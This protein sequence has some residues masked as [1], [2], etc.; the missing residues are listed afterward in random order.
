MALSTY[1]DLH[2]AVANWSHRSDLTS[3]LPD[4]ILVAENRI[5][6]DVRCREMETALS[7]TIASG[8]I[9]LPTGYLDLKFAYVDGSPTQS[10][11]RSSASQVYQSYPNRVSDGKPKMIAR[12][13]TNLI[14]G[15]YPDST[16]TI[17]G[18][19]Y[20]Q[21]TS[22][23]TSANALFVKYPDLYLFATLAE[24]ATY[25][26]DQNAVS[27]WNQKFQLIND[28]INAYE[29]KEYGSGGGLSVSVG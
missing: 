8:V 17:K 24:V 22:I 12:E 10:L 6:R 15:P 13:G 11:T 26:R 3:I 20:Q 2:T 1:S 27:E 21:L 7:A 16:Y 23:Q 19:Y 5:W 18:I 25:T 29:A 28:Q 9:A 14:F 4:L